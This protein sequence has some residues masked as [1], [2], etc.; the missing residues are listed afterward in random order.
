MAKAAS[1]SASTA[2][3][4]ASPLAEK[5]PI[6]TDGGG[7]VIGSIK[8]NLGGQTI[9]PGDLDR[10]VWPSGAS[11]MFQIPGLDG[12]DERKE[13]EGIVLSVN[14]VRSYWKNPNP[15]NSPPDC[16]SIDCVS[17]V[18]TPGGDC[19]KCPLAKFGTA[20][21]PDGKTGRGQACKEKA[22]L[23]ILRPGHT[24]PTVIRIPPSSLQ[25]WKKFGLNLAQ[26]KRV[27]FWRCVVK[28]SLKTE[29]SSD[30]IEYPALV[31]SLVS[32][33]TPEEGASIKSF[34]DVMREVMQGAAAQE[35]STTDAA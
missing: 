2:L 17:G 13:I 22:V 9:N 1:E 8:E 32:V 11:K 3:A 27:P 31:P 26:E 16:S 21:K 33:T 15:S 25:T 14:R 35:A 4:T 29:K 24:L 30:G 34:V 7:D 6:I 19:A 28:L 18:G 12:S 23:F 10:V 5:F 20:V